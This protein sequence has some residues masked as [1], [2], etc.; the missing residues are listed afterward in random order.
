MEIKYE[1]EKKELRIAA[2][3]KDKRL[4]SSLSIAGGVLLLSLLIFFIILHRLAI[5]KRNIYEQQVRNVATQS[6]LDGEMAERIRLARDLHDG[7]GGMLSVVKLNLDDREHLQDARELLDRSIN[8]LHRVV[9]HM[10]PES[11]L[12]Y[13]LKASLKDFCLSVPNAQFHY[14]GDESRLSD[15]IEILIYRCTYELVNNAIKYARASTI[16]V[17]LVQDTDR[18]SLTVHDDGCGFDTEIVRPGMGFSNLRNRIAA[19]NGKI[20]IHSSP[21]KGTEIYAEIPLKK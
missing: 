20:S 18:T 13:G 19:C 15:R 10:M 8:E 6:A 16:N 12:H 21:G 9:H 5:S 1:T 4:I 2:L 7:L 14:F 17:Q 11:L 3:E